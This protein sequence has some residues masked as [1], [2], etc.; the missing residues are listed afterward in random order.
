MSLLLSPAVATGNMISLFY[1]LN[2]EIDV[3]FVCGLMSVNCQ[4]MSP[5]PAN[6]WAVHL[7]TVTA[8]SINYGIRNQKLLS[9]CRNQNTISLWPYT[10]FNFVSRPFITS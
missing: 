3:R 1:Y 7:I 6:K 8:E 9:E 2:A 10:Q 4:K 5:N